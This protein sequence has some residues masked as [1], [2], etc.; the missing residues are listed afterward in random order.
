MIAFTDE[1]IR[2]EHLVDA[3][4]E[5]MKINDEIIASMDSQSELLKKL[6]AIYKKENRLLLAS[7]FIM[8][9]LLASSLTVNIL[10]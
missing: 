5:V 3:Q 9:L 7:I 4:R 1:I 2:L 10:L 6:L 8:A